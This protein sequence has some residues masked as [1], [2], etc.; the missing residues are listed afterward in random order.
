MIRRIYKIGP[1]LGLVPGAARVFVSA[2]ITLTFL[3]AAAVAAGAENA[4]SGPAAETTESSAAIP[5][6]A[7]FTPNTDLV[8]RIGRTGQKP[9]IDGHLDDAAWRSAVRL[10]NFCEISPGENTRPAVDT[11]AMITYDSDNLYVAFV[12]YDD[13]SGIRAAITDRDDIFNDDCIGIM[14]DTFK[15][16][17][18]AY[19]FFV[20][21]YGIQGD[22]RRTG[23]D[24][25]ASYDAVWHSAGRI[26]EDGWTAEIAVPFRSVRFPDASTQDWGLH[27]LRVRPRGSLEKLSWAPVSRD[28]T[29]LFCNAGTING[30][31]GIN[32]GKNV[33]V[34]P[35][36]VGCR[37]RNL[38]DPD[39]PG[40]AL[41]DKPGDAVTGFGIK[42]GISPNF[43]LDFT[44][45]PDFSQIESDEAQIDANT[46]FALFF[47][48]RRAFFQEGA[49]IFNT[50][51]GTVYTRSINDPAMAAK[52]TGKSGRT[53]VGYLACRDDATPYIVPY[54]ESSQVVVN[55]R[56]YSNIVRAKR[57]ILQDSYLGVI[58]T[59]RRNETNG[60]SNTNVGVDAEIRFL[61]FYRLRAQVQGS[62][63]TEPDD[64]TLTDGLD[65]I[66]FGGRKQYDSSFNKESFGGHAVETSLARNAR[67]WTF[68]TWYKDYSPTFRA[69]NGFVTANNHRIARFWTGYNFY[70]DH[71]KL[72]DLLQPQIHGGFEYNYDGLLKDKWIAP[73]IRVM[74]RK[75]TSV[76][77]GYAF[78]QTR[79][80]GVMVKGIRWVLCKLTTNFSA[81]LSGGA[82]AEVG[83]SL[84][85]GEDNPRLGFKRGLEIWSTIRP[86]PQISLELTFRGFSM[87]E[88]ET[89]FHPDTG[90]LISKGDNIFD[91]YVG[92]VLLTYQLTKNLFMR[93]VTQYIETDDLIEVDPLL[94][95]KLNPFTLF[96]LGSSHDF[97]RLDSDI[98]G[99]D[100]AYKQTDRT[101]FIKFQY[102][103][104]I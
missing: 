44:Y 95:Y 90:D 88:L 97:V 64:S 94:S 47:P 85:R 100:P 70:T 78:R 48:E 26:T 71:G 4:R 27:I 41:I 59:D 22:L 83:H 5:D 45:N 23:K 53:T 104:R 60:G 19:E 93:L 72:T 16:Q 3:S 15:D 82:N 92:R 46:T 79:Y 28:E 38:D 13:P 43:T 52:I 80:A 86:A 31:E 73:A 24:E 103:I 101:Y 18:N 75:Q 33:E 67:R 35:Y 49:D 7:T 55:G 102:L 51:T 36:V 77:L 91:V 1:G 66:R 29:C 69:E 62:F 65:R 96:F 68:R 25:D 76:C 2:M 10:G 58:A 61:D 42:Y 40:S 34:L 30:L 50:L 57:D 9:V 56:S 20:N 98:P 11:G 6:P 87:T 99:S 39:D 37:S 14:V 74:F 54:E 17:K 32:Q 12:C 8:F 21:P 63:T 89:H 81:F 84:V